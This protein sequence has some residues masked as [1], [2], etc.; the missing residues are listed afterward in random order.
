MN[1]GDVPG[2]YRLGHVPR[3]CG[4]SQVAQCMCVLIDHG[5]N[6]VAIS[7]LCLKLEYIKTRF[8]MCNKALMQHKLK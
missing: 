4:L 2:S 3:V 6:V 5:I 8:R 1:F 7:T